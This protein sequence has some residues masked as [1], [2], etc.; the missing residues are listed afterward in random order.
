MFTLS[1]GGIPRAAAE[2]R[3][4]AERGSPPR[5]SS[6]LEGGV[7]KRDSLVLEGYQGPQQHHGVKRRGVNPP[8]SSSSGGGVTPRRSCSAPEGRGKMK[9]LV[10]EGYQGSQQHHSVK[11]GGVNPLAAAAPAGGG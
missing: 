8:R 5:S 2:P 3:R 10:P 6:A 7:A 9:P 1:A 4:Q 11:P